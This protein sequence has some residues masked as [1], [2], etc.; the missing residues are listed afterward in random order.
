MNDRI[1]MFRPLSAAADTQIIFTDDA[2]KFLKNDSCILIIDKNV[3]V[4]YPELRKFKYIEIEA[5]EEN[6]SLSRVESI[7]ARLL[8]FEAGRDAEIVGIGGGIT[9]DLAGFVSAIYK[10]GTALTLIPTTILAQA[11]AGLGGKNGVNFGGIKNIIGT[12]RQPARIIISRRVRRTLSQDITR[13]GLV[14]IIKTAA[15]ADKELFEKLENTSAADLSDPLSEAVQTAVEAASK[16]KLRIVRLDSDEHNLRR[17]L[18][19]GHTIGHPIEAELHIPH[20]FA[21]GA[22]MIAAQKIAEAEFSA[23]QEIRERLYALLKKIEIPEIRFPKAEEILKFLIEDKKRIENDICF[24]FVRE[25]GKAET[26]KIKTDKLY[27]KYKTLCE[28]K[29]K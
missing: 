23:P 22:G 7:I 9:C 18:N 2:F 6:K 16:D 21:V 15:I 4:N 3:L 20:G 28:Y 5:I 29:I 17:N 19:F 27:E 24:V 10:R 14:E 1:E 13:A 8:E 11:D 26:R 12:I 25:I